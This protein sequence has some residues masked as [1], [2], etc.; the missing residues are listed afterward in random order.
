MIGEREK[1]HYVFIK[2][3]NAFV[4]DHT[5]HRRRKYSFR[6]CLQAFRTAEKLKCHIKDCFK[7][8]YE[9]TIKMPKK[10]EYI[11][12]KNFGKKDH[13]FMIYVDLKSI[14]VAEWKAKPK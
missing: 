12:F 14:L 13:L 8:K 6:Y 10:S 3:F 7:I 5:L 2:D 9:Q 1:K 11:E 4:Y